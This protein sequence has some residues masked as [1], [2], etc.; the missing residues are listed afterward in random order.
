MLY[1]D[2]GRAAGEWIPNEFGGHENLAAV[3]FLKELNVLVHREHPGAITIAEES[4]SWPGVSRPTYTGGLGFTFKWNM[5]WMH[6]TLDY[7]DHDP[8]HRRYHQNQITFGLLYAFTENFVLALSHDEVV[9]G[10]RTLLDKMPG[11]LWQRYANLRAL[12]AYMYGHPGKKMLFMGGEFGQWRE[13]NHDASLDWHLC[14]EAPHAGLQRLIRDLNRLYH[15]EPA[16]HEIDFDWAGFQWIDFHDAD[17]SVIA[18]LRQAREGRSRVV[19]VCNFTPVPRL[20]YRI[21]VP[22]AGWYRELL[23]SDAAC[24]GGSNLGNAG[25][26]LAEDAPYHGLPHSLKLT[27]PPLSVLFLKR[28][29]P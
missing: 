10:K 2:Y 21:G 28:E 11:D 19:C 6:D 9:H 25:G 3:A 23:N 26:R 5:G 1:L 13:W 8:V 27:L 24:Y 17:N 29:G 4:T 16:L 15:E 20:D 7:F 12:F 14:G 22:D 18:F